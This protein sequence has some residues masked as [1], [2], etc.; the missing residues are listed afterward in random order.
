MERRL[1]LHDELKD[2]LGSDKVFFQPP[3]SIKLSYPCIVYQRE[4]KNV[5]RADNKAYQIHDKYTV[6][7][8]QR[9][10]EDDHVNNLLTHFQM[11]EHDQHFAVDNLY[12]DIFTLFY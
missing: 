2:I 6:T 1:K 8:I 3:E 9:T 4:P 5:R 11:I 7:V 12:H 10:P